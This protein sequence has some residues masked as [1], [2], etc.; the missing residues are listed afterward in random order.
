MGQETSEQ[1]RRQ[2]VGFRESFHIQLICCIFF[3]MVSPSEL[4]FVN[5]YVVSKEKKFPNLNHGKL[6]L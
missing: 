3:S 1:H 5:E 6:G 2:G 4:S